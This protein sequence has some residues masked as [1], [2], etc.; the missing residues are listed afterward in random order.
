MGILG[1]VLLVLFVIVSL[2]LVFLVVV[3]N[4]GSEGL[5]GIFAGSGQAAFGARSSNV[6]VKAT[7]VLGGL[8]FVFAFAL[9]LVNKGSVGDVEA[10]ALKKSQSAPQ[11]D[12]WN[13]QPQAQAPEALAPADGQPQLGTPPAPV[14][15]PTPSGN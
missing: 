3:Q 2:L 12:W 14:P 5:G 11:T 4:E 13:S 10:A 1:I 9:A 8:F 6:I 7:Y 15:A